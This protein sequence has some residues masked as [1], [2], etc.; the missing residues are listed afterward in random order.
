[1]RSGKGVE[2]MSAKKIYVCALILFLVLFSLHL[3]QG[4]AVSEVTEESEKIIYYLQKE[5]S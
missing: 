5:F 1:M 3:V 4:L 2:N